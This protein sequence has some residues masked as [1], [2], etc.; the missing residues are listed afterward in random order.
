MKT[1]AELDAMVDDVLRVQWS[2]REGRKVPEVEQLALTGNVGVEIE[3]TVL[4]ADLA[5]SSALVEGY[6]DWFAAEMIKIFLM[7]AAEVVRNNDGVITAY[8]GDRVMGIFTGDFKNSN[9]AKCGLQINYAITKI[10]N[11]KLAARYPKSLY[12][13]RHGVGIDTSSLLAARTGVRAAN[14]LAWVGTA[15]NDA[16]KLSS[17]RHADNATYISSSV[18]QRLNDLS[19]LGG[20]PRRDMWTEFVW[21]E[22]SEKAYRSSWWWRL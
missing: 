5:Q 13:I 19:R 12:A 7:C 9:A 1:L 22:K 20:D 2:R 6:A 15:A 10:V 18:Y 21:E 4:Y 16:A 11:P 8:D 17:L 14:D 3:A